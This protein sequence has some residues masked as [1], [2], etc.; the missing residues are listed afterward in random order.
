MYEINLSLFFA[1]KDENKPLYLN[2]FLW[3]KF[4]AGKSSTIS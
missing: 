4:S 3:E 1:D 2:S